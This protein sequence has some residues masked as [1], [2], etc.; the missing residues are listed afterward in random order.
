MRPLSLIMH[1]TIQKCERLHNVQH[2][3]ALAPKERCECFFIFFDVIAKSESICPRLY[4]VHAK[5]TTIEGVLFS[6]LIQAL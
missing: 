4:S 5:L 3:S 1:F 6:E 2:F